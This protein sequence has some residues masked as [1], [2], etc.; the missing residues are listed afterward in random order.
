MKTQ[1]KAAMLLA[2]AAMTL[3]ACGSTGLTRPHTTSA[4]EAS[5]IEVHS[6]TLECPPADD[7]QNNETPPE[8]QDNAIP[9]VIVGLAADFA[10]KLGKGLLEQA[11]QD[12]NA[13]WAASGVASCM[14]AQGQSV[15]DLP[16]S[17]TREVRDGSGRTVGTPG[18]QLSGS[19]SFAPTEVQGD[20]NGTSIVFNPTSFV[21]G[22]QAPRREG[23]G[24]KHVIVYLVFSETPFLGTGGATGE[25]TQL[26]GA[27]RIDLGRLE[28]G[29]TYGPDMLKH[30]ASSTV[31]ERP[32]SS[33]M[34]MT[35][36]VFETDDPSL[37]L[38][39][40]ISAFDDNEDAI[41]DALRNLL[42]GGDSGDGE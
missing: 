30:A 11:R 17:I 41:V 21:Y 34:V 5:E 18:F 15:E 40:F 3:T 28:D 24:R 36:I 2:S 39:A 7:L 10:F 29:L 26:T 9:P 16:L 25:E 14:P 20:R 31:L 22:R 23:S 27:M 38:D 42:G 12:R 6:V 35:S 4:P 1:G 33:S 32:R 37:A 19:I 13:V 8:V